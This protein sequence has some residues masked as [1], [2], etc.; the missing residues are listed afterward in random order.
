[1]SR[2]MM[3]ASPQGG[4]TQGSALVHYP[5]SQSTSP[6]VPSAPAPAA[7]GRLDEH[8][9]FERPPPKNAELFN[10]KA[11]G[12]SGTNAN[13]NGNGARA[14]NGR[15]R[16]NT[17][18]SPIAAGLVEKLSAMAIVETGEAPVAV[19]QPGMGAGEIAMGAVAADSAAL[20]L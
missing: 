14:E 8:D 10:P 4:G 2:V 11:A 15:S 18:G 20:S 13:G 19:S 9:A 12:R 17:G 6:Q 3:A 1:M 16:A 5:N 7:L